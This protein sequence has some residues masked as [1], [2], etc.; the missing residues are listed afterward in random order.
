M[1]KPRRYIQKPDNAR[2]LLAELGVS[3]TTI[4]RGRQRDH[5][6]DRSSRPH[7]LQTTLSQEEEVIVVEPG[8]PI[9]ALFPLSLKTS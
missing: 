1:P 7:D 2:E 6:H 4:R 8:F 9:H 5:V 3:E